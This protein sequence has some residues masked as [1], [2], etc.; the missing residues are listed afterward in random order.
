MESVFLSIVQLQDG[1]NIYLFTSIHQNSSLTS[2]MMAIGVPMHMT[3]PPMTKHTQAMVV[4]KWDAL[5]ACRSFKKLA[6]GKVNAIK[7][8]P[9]G[10]K[11]S[12]MLDTRGKMRAR[13]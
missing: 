3:R 8:P 11:T 7:D 1:T 13:K 12:K 2:F 6:A 9:I 4:S 10:T 5:S